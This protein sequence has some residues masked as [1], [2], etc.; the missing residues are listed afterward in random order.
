[1]NYAGYKEF[2]KELEKYLHQIQEKPPQND[3]SELLHYSIG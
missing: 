2:K 3:L 1:M